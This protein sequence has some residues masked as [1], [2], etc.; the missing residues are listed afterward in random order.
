MVLPAS[1]WASVS[2]SW[3]MYEKVPPIASLPAFAPACE[4]A[5]PM[6]A[7]SALMFRPD[8]VPLYKSTP[9]S[10]MACVVLL[11]T[12]TKIAP[13]TPPRLLVAP[14]G[15]SSNEGSTSSTPLASGELSSTLGR[16]K[17]NVPVTF[18]NC[19]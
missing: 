15:L 9:D 6:M 19:M 4:N 5:K 1:K 7:S 10:T 8:W 18:M 13:P 3:V 16:W 11:S 12:C 14:L 2:L 17:L